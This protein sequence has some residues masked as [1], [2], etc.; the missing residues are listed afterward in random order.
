M[1][2][3]RSIKALVWL[4][5]LLAPSA[6]F[7]LTPLFD[8][9]YG[10]GGM[11]GWVTGGNDGGFGSVVTEGSCFSNNDTTGI[12][13]TGNRAGMV[14][15][16]REARL[17]SKGTL[18]SPVFTAGIGFSFK[19]LTE[20][21][22]L[23]RLEAMP[24]DFDVHVLTPEGRALKSVRLRTAVVNL[25][26]G[27]PSVAANGAFSTHFVDTRKFTG[28]PV[29]IQFSQGTRR[30]GA[31][32]FTL[33]DEIIRFD[34]GDTQVLPYR[35]VARAG[36]S[37]SDT[38]RLRLDGSLSYDPGDLLLEYY[39]RVKGD[40]FQREG[41]FPCIDDL[42]PG[43]HQAT[44]V[45]SN[46]LYTD[47]DTIHF[48]IDEPVEA[49]PEEPADTTEEEDEEE[50]EEDTNKDGEFTLDCSD[51]LIEEEPDSEEETM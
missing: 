42:D 45:V 9:G 7:S 18:T 20:R 35:P 46:G 6:A 37:I 43:R 51:G 17:G 39:W 34:P 29:R 50:D 4:L 12:V 28:Q 15:S 14:R 3:T 44:L 24:V 49:E 2:S 5:L 8:D 22:H 33:V 25:E 41:E 27:C 10:V 1:R 31:G 26:R 21:M 40:L 13:F 47:A 36:V 19:A 38:E 48:V 11:G 32:F 23:D 30:A 16:G